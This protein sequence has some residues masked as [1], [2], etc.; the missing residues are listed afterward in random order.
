MKYC[1]LDRRDHSLNYL[2]VFQDAEEGE[3]EDE[4]EIDPTVSV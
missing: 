3:E 1:R 2:C 4:G